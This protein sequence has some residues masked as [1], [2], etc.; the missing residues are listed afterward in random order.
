MP[1]KFLRAML[2]CRSPW[3][4]ECSAGAR[5]ENI[6]QFWTYSFRLCSSRYFFLLNTMYF[7]NKKLLAEERNIAAP[8]AI[9]FST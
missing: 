8:F 4:A 1:I 5:L 7:M 2:G 3:K 6:I 9:L